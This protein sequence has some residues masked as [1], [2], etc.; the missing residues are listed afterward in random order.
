V[1]S[2]S[3]RIPCC[4]RPRHGRVR[5]TDFGFAIA[6]EDEAIY[7]QEALNPVQQKLYDVIL[8]DIL[9]ADMSGHEVTAAI[10]APNQ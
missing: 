10:R 3:A 9:M 8:M 7:E 2:L 1:H 5:T 6:Q 4:L